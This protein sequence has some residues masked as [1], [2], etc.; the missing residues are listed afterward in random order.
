MMPSRPC[1]R[2][3]RANILTLF[4]HL[5]MKK[6]SDSLSR[7]KNSHK[8]QSKRAKIKIKINKNKNKKKKKKSI[9]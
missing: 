2:D 5:T 3:L 4:L 6:Q 9:D 7:L 8:C 1:K